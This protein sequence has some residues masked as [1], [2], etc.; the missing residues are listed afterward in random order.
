MFDFGTRAGEVAPVVLLIDR[1]EDPVTPLLL[2]WTYQAMVHELLG[3]RCNRVDLPAS[4]NVRL[5]LRLCIYS[6]IREK[7]P[8]R[9]AP[10]IGTFRRLKELRRESDWHTCAEGHVGPNNNAGEILRRDRRGD[11]APLL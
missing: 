9:T 2:Q 11:I 8:G 7:A 10:A 6:Q 3:I 5:S 4:A 1:K